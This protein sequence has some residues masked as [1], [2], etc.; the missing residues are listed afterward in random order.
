M[1]IH[2][3]IHRPRA[4]GYLAAANSRHGFFSLYDSVYSEDRLRKIYIIKGG[5]GTGKSTLMDACAARASALGY[6]AEVYLCSSDPASI[7]GVIIPS[8]EA[9]ILDGTAPHARDP[10]YPGV[11]ANTVDVG[12][13]WDTSVLTDAKSAIKRQIK[14]KSEAYGRA[15]RCLFGAGTALDDVLFGVMRAF[16]TVKAEQAVHRIFDKH[17]ITHAEKGSVRRIFTDAI[18][19]SGIVH[20]DTFER[21]A[22]TV[23]TV[24][25]HYG[26]E[27]LLLDLIRDE[28]LRRGRD[29]TL[30]LSPLSPEHTD[31]VYFDSL[32]VLFTSA[33][34]ER[35]DVKLINVK[36]FVN[37]DTLAASRAKLRMSEKI[38]SAL[39]D[40]ALV[41]L[42]EAGAYHA[43]TEAIYASAMNFDAVGELTEQILSEVFG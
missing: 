38:K 19:T 21:R 11:C 26:A 4:E 32:G 6:D 39:L 8:L 17:R 43:K 40:E 41:S 16:N 36:R 27:T 42:S 33:Q 2:A 37:A 20:L 10:V 23:Y 15:Y 22:D 3:S 14:A 34:T 29:F 35:T 12:R 13:F 5:P 31:A 7:D 28:A 9:A 24:S 25:S 1:K 18:S 30:V